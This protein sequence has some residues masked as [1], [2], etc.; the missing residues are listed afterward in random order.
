MS[1]PVF[2]LV[3]LN[4]LFPPPWRAML[5]LGSCRR[6]TLYAIIS[7]L[8]IDLRCVFNA[9]IGSVATTDWW[10]TAKPKS[11]PLGEDIYVTRP[12]TECY[13]NNARYFEHPVR[14]ELRVLKSWRSGDVWAKLNVS[15]THR[16]IHSLLIENL[17]TF[18]Q[19]VHDDAWHIASR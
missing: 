13:P 17:A 18:C 6:S 15:W 12:P 14:N 11:H 4:F 1:A 10:C 9:I 8:Q 5:P 3:A 16:T 7:V 19:Q 2:V